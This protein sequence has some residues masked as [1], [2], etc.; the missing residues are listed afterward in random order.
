ML[1]DHEVRG[2]AAWGYPRPAEPDPRNLL[3]WAVLVV[4][5]TSSQSRN[6]QL[7]VPTVLSLDSG[8]V[9]HA[10][11]IWKQHSDPTVS[12][13]SFH[14]STCAPGKE[15]RPVNFAFVSGNWRGIP[16][17]FLGQRCGRDLRGGRGLLTSQAG[18]GGGPQQTSDPRRPGP[19]VN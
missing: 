6:F 11:Q 2:W 18:G 8:S 17:S 13:W 19:R 10:G 16:F 9:A 14:R 5:C 1:E 7:S 3:S 4:G 15:W 12:V